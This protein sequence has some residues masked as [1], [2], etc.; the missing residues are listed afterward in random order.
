MK[1][2]AI[3]LA[4]AL[5]AFSFASCNKAEVETPDNEIKLNVKI[6]SPSVDTKAAKTSW[7]DGD[8]INLWFNQNYSTYPDLK[9]K[10]NGSDW[11]V[12]NVTTSGNAIAESGYVKCA[13]ESGNNIHYYKA[14]V[15]DSPYYRVV[16]HAYKDG[17]SVSSINGTNSYEMPLFATNKAEVQYTLVDNVLTFNLAEWYFINDL[18]VT[19]T[20]LIGDSRLSG[21]ENFGM[22]LKA[23]VVASPRT[24]S[25]VY[26]GN[27]GK[28]FETDGASQAYYSYAA[29]TNVFSFQKTNS[30]DG[31]T[32]ITISIYSIGLSKKFTKTVSGKTLKAAGVPQFVTVDFST[33]TEEDL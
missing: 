2:I 30:N 16:F 13:Y 32:D 24:I 28:S 12:Y 1:K 21:S 5:A 17:N 14:S 19:V 6:A 18:Q 27:S 11:E 33:F 15:W 22:N 29:H 9:L 7:V 4:A 3:I 31:V 25:G 26:V 20:N 8:I 23:D 10:Y